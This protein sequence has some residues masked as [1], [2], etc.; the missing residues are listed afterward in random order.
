LTA[1][2][3][4]NKRQRRKTLYFAISCLVFLGALYFF[5]VGGDRHTIKQLEKEITDASQQADRQKILQPILE[6][7][8]K[9]EQAAA[10]YEADTDDAPVSVSDSSEDYQAT[11]ETLAQQCNLTLTA[12]APDIPSILSG[13]GNIL[14]DMTTRGAFSDFRR[15]ILRLAGVPYLQ[16]V[17]RF[18]VAPDSDTSE[19][20]M[21]LRLR[22]QIA[23]DTEGSQP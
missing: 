15:L 13:D 12:I 18:R 21:R 4:G 3:T 7:L 11:L 23:S 1:A 9:E 19:L 6:S 10:G 2:A 16:G 14:V 17:D 20:E 22:I 8:Q 5:S